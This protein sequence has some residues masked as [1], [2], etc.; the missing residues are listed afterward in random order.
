MRARTDQVLQ[1]KLER[2]FT[3]RAV[4]LYESMIWTEARIAVEM[5]QG[6]MNVDACPSESGQSVS[7]EGFSNTMG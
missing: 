1:C 7:S 4:A 3:H 2:P 5:Q 6:S